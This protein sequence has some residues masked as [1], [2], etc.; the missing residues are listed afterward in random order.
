M[1]H[2]SLWYPIKQWRELYEYINFFYLHLGVVF[3][4]K[5]MVKNFV[6]LVFFFNYVLIFRIG[7]LFLSFIFFIAILTLIFFYFGYFCVFFYF[8]LTVFEYIVLLVCPEPE[9]TLSGNRMRLT[10]H[11]SSHS[12]FISKVIV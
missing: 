9:D 6:Y 2:Y 8:N 1:Y 3:S 4:V 11:F 7:C 12:R 10:Y 5:N